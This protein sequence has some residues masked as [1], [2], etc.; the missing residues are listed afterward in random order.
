MEASSDATPMVSLCN[1]GL[2]MYLTMPMANPTSSVSVD[3]QGDYHCKSTSPEGSSLVRIVELA[4][5]LE[6]DRGSRRHSMC[7]ASTI[8]CRKG[9]WVQINQPSK[10]DRTHLRMLGVVHCYLAA[11]PGPVQQSS[12]RLHKMLSLRPAP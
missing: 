9:R 8:S 6:L 2:L 1:L 4:L 3:K 12:K 10:G 5:R 11:M 7:T